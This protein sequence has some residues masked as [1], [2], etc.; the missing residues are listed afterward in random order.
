VISWRY[1]QKVNDFSRLGL[2]QEISGFRQN[3]FYGIISIYLQSDDP[4]KVFGRT[5]FQPCFDG[6]SKFYCYF[7]EKRAPLLRPVNP[8]EKALPPLLFRPANPLKKFLVGLPREG[9]LKAL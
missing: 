2:W 9:A 7:T 8:L 4:K 3:D 6:K 5:L 1:L